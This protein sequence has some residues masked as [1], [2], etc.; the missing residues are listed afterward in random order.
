MRSPRAQAILDS[1]E[2]PYAQLFA[3]ST[4]M[5]LVTDHSIR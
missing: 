5:K 3:S 2:Q 1:S 4:L